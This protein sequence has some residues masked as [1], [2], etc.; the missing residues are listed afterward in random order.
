MPLQGDAGSASP[1]HF[2]IR[3]GEP[4]NGILSHLWRKHGGNIR[5]KGIVT[6][7]SSSIYGDDPQYSPT[8]LAA[9]SSRLIFSSK[10][11]PGQWLQWDFHEMH[12]IPTQYSIQAHGSTRNG[13]HLRSW[14]LERSIDGLTWTELDRRTHSDDFNG[15]NSV[16][17]FSIPKSIECR[18]IR[19]RQTGK[20]HEG[21]DMLAFCHFEIFGFLVDCAGTFTS[22]RSPIRS[23]SPS[24]PSSSSSS[25]VVDTTRTEIL[26]NPAKP[27]EGILSHFSQMHGGNSHEKGIVIITSS[28]VI[29]NDPGH[30]PDILLDSNMQRAFISKNELNEWVQFDFHA[31]RVSPAHYSIQSPCFP[32]GIGHL[33]SWVLEGSNDGLSWTELD[34]QTNNDNLNGPNA[35]YRFSILNPIEFRL[36]RLR[37]TGANH[38]G[39]NVLALCRFEV[40]GALR[41]SQDPLTWSVT[42]ARSVSISGSANIGVDQTMTEIE[43]NSVRPLDGILSLR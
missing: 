29:D 37:L 7:T 21:N 10:N 40:F 6:L 28:S 17:A 41:E 30:S 43:L 33:K 8:N 34:R 18:F 13:S 35:F 32:R 16:H 3:R 22:S 11:E 24:L 9:V 20:N 15:P 39:N 26:M 4:L 36:I 5:E 2:P 1:I 19:L 42:P 25:V 38:S 27:F 31:I 23:V 12:V 14:V